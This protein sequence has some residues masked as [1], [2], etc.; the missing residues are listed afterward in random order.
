M[1]FVAAARKSKTVFVQ[2]TAVDRWV[3]MELVGRVL[4]PCISP[5]SQHFLVSVCSWR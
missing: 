2:S 3:T 1:I 4:Q 5:T